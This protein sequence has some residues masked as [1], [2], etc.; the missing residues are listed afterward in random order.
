[1]AVS[2]RIGLIGS[3]NL[4]KNWSNQALIGVS[5]G[6][7]EHGSSLLQL[8]RKIGFNPVA[9]APALYVFASANFFPLYIIEHWLEYRGT[10]Q[11]LDFRFELVFSSLGADQASQPRVAL[12]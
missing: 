12:Q 2:A 9:I 1:M 5:V 10:F 3:G 4:L 8:D 11:H 6:Q 7:V